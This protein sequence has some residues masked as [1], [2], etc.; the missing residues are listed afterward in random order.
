M[1]FEVLVV[2]LLTVINGLLAMSELAIVSAR[3]AKLKVMAEQGSQ[4]AATALLL[5][6]EPGRFLSSVQI[7]ITLVGV[8][9]G[10][11][12]GAT[13]GARLA[14]ALPG[15]GVPPSLAQPLGMGGVVILITYL[16]LI[17]GELVPKQIALRASEEVAARVAPAMK[18]ISRIAAPLVWLLDRSGQVVL[19]LLGQSGKAQRDLSDE[20]IKMVISE[21]ASAGV[22]EH[23]ETEMIAGVMRIADRTARGLMTPRHEVATLEVSDTAAEAAERFRLSRRSRLP[24]RDGDVENVIGVVTSADL[25]AADT[26]D[27]TFDLRSLVHPAPVV[28]EGMDSLDVIQRLRESPV[29]MVLVYDEYGHFEGIITPMDLL[30]A[31]TGEFLHHDSEDEP[32][33]TVREDGSMLVAGWMQVD[34]FADRVGIKLD[35]DREFETVAGLVLEVA[36]A[37]PQVGD[38]VNIQGW[39][40]EVV[41]L[42]GRRIDKVLVS[43]EPAREK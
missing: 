32:K 3:P 22:I 33:V 40:V 37:L 23:A 42:D 18:L 25:L 39:R 26:A 24:V 6:E 12:S 29:H 4:G 21:A 41:D 30:E 11:F 14:E 17:V 31:I 38:V 16:S 1:I 20:E 28:H 2:L 5:A 27:P 19:R 43:K 13:L 7:G 9:A 8:L 34:E 15:W 36:G 10:A 35:S